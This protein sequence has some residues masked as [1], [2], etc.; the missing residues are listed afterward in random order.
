MP[1]GV[2]GLVA[3]GSVETVWKQVQLFLFTCLCYQDGLACHGFVTLEREDLC[4]CSR[5]IVFG[6]P[7]NLTRVPAL[8][9]TSST[10]LYFQAF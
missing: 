7:V 6:G 8:C 3:R 9:S 10:F 5:K 1:E 4:C 2:A